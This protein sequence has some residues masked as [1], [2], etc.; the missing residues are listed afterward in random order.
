MGR[1]QARWPSRWVGA[2]T[3]AVGLSTTCLASVTA[4]Q[5][6]DEPRGLVIA[7]IEA[8]LALQSIGEVSPKDLTDHRVDTALSVIP[9]VEV[10]YHASHWH[11]YLVGV[12]TL[13][14]L[15]L[16]GFADPD[17]ERLAAALDLH[18]GRPVGPA[19]AKR[20]G[21]LALLLNTWGLE[22]ACLPASEG[23]VCDAGLERQWATHRPID[24]PSDTSRM[25]AN[26]SAV[27]GITVLSPR[28]GGWGGGS[29]ATYSV[30]VFTPDGA[31]QGWARATQ[32][33]GLPSQ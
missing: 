12:T 24:W 17:V 21:L 9:V 3:L 2:V 13:G 31:V 19:R 1:L 18:L 30:F 10:R 16:G 25:L 7:D 33:A 23:R 6:Q 29:E 14:I 26:G 28:R 15:R 4:Q 20:A 32:R 8:R 5:G 27:V 11:P 22:Q